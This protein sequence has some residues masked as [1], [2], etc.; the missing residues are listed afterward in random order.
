M[1][2]YGVGRKLSRV[3]CIGCVE[4]VEFGAVIDTVAG[5]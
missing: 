3:N 4:T 1:N 5:M 2:V